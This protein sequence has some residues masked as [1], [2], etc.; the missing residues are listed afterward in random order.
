MKESQSKPE[1]LSYNA[2][3]TTRKEAV[4]AKPDAARAHVDAVLEKYVRPE[5][6]PN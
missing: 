4:L 5:P 3:S 2:K 1:R 6:E